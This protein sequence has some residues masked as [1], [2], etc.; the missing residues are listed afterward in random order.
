MTLALR[1]PLLLSL[2]LVSWLMVTGC[3]STHQAEVAPSADTKRELLREVERLG[4]LLYQAHTSGAHKLEFS[5]QQREVFAELRPLYCAGNYTELGVTDDTNGS[6]YWYAIKFSDDA[7]TVVFGRHLKLIQ[8]ANG[9][10][11][12]SLSSRGCLDVP[13]TQ[14][15]SLFASHSASDYPNE[16][17]VFLSLFHQQKI[18]VDTSS[19]LYRVEAGTIQ[20]IG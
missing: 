16:F 19:G 11:D 18:Y 3:Q 14:T 8:K 12:S 17:H 5:S 13:L 2:C 7:D 15:G 6:T 20:Q 10:Y 9:E 1:K 4:H